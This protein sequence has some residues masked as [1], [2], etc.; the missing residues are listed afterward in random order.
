MT[1]DALDPVI[2]PPA[3]LQIMGV[4]VKVTSAEFQLLRR[5]TGVSD[6]VLSKHLAALA[7]AGYVAIKKGPEAGRVRTWAAATREGK[8]AFQGHVR[9]LQR[10]AGLDLTA[11][12]APSAPGEAPQGLWAA[13]VASV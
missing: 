5:T 1:P 4:L 2:H 3:R 7:D 13:G 6:S 11:E 9:A 12:A 10:L 8:G